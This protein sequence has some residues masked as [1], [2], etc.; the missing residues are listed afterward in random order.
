MGHFKELAIMRDDVRKSGG[1]MSEQ[2]TFS[3]DEMGH[4]PLEVTDSEI[5]GMQRQAAKADLDVLK[6][7]LDY[8][9]DRVEIYK[10]RVTLENLKHF[11][12]LAKSAIRILE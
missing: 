3:L 4:F 6:R 7:E 12:T 10:E 11:R 8:V 9:I 1:Q 5:E 2:D